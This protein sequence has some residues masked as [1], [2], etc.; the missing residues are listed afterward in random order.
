VDATVEP[1][2]ARRIY[3][4]L[5]D[6]ILSGALAPGTRLPGELDL[7]AAH[8]VSRVTIRRALEQL[9][10]ETLVERRSGVGT[11]VRGGGILPR[12]VVDFADVFSHLKEMGRRT[13]AR[14][15]SFGYVTPPSAISAALGLASGQR[16]QRAVRV[17][18]LNGQPFSYL[19]T[20]VP[21]WLGLT[22]SEADL[23]AV[24]LLALLER[25]GVVVARA[26]QSTGACLAGPEVA[27]S[28]ETETGA[29]LLS[30]TRLVQDDSGRPVEHLH[31]LYRPDRFTFQMELQRT[32]AMD[33]R[34]WSP[35]PAMA[36]HAGAKP[37]AANSSS[38]AA[39][40]PHP[41]RKSLP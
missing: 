7:A 5:R 16:A 12:I 14:L 23:A 30:L 21:E 8:G 26:C 20:H 10:A 34:R 41:K 24:P 38:A 13:E 6:H 28:L 27:A 32:G 9:A 37:V 17:R 2:K 29:P 39:A 3:L 11:F 18:Q 15:L 19:T 4:L 1:F 22:Y 36:A 31:A 40:T 33:A 35:L 25:S